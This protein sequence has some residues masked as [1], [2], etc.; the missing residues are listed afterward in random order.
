MKP[1]EPD[2]VIRRIIVEYGSVYAYVYMT[3]GS[4]KLLD[5][6]SFKQPFRMEKRDVLDEARDCYDQL[7]DWLND[8]IN[9][10]PLQ[11]TDD[12]QP[13]SGDEED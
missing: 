6:E 9:V 2:H 7:W 4:G 8:T 1:R 13:K 5:E 12:G 3:D 11:D 10:T